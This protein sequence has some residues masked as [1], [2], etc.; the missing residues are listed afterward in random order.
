MTQAEPDTI[1]V[2]L[3]GILG[4]KLPVE[5]EIPV[6]QMAVGKQFVYED[7]AYRISRL[8][9]DDV[10]HPIVYVGVTDILL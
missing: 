10:E 7:I 9:I 5:T 3:H 2:N 1:R 6:V 8:I 4:E